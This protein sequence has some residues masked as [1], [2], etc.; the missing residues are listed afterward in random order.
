VHPVSVKD[1]YQFYKV[2]VYFNKADGLPVKM[3]GYDWPA[4]IYPEG[5]LVEQ[6]TYV[7]VKSEEVVPAEFQL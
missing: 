2:K 3:E 7:D 4:G 5:R 1:K 6:F